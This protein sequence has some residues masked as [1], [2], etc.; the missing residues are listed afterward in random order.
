MNPVFDLI[1]TLAKPVVDRFFPDKKQAQEFMQQLQ[2]RALDADVQTAMGQLEVNKVEAAS[3][4]PFVSRWRPFIGWVC[5]VAF[6]ANFVLLPTARILA[7]LA[8]TPLDIAP[9]DMGEMMPVLLGMLGLG[10]MRTY[11]KVAGATK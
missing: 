9:L 6:A 2:L 10:G 7:A 4:D 5:G 11:E 1:G 8:G 3:S